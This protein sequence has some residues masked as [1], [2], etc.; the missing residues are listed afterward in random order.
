MID[1]KCNCRKYILQFCININITNQWQHAHSSSFTELIVTMVST[2][3]FSQLGGTGGPL[4][5]DRILP[6]AQT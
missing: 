1:N 3:F 6:V 5:C 2:S 4:Y